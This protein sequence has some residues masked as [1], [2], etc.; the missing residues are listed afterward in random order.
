MTVSTKTGQEVL[1]ELSD[2]IED[3]FQ[4]TTT[5][6]GN[7]GGTTLTDTGLGRFGTDQL[8]DQWVRFTSG[9]NDN[10]IVRIKSNTGTSITFVRAVTGQVANSVTYEVHKYDPAMK[11][12]AIDRAMDLGFPALSRVRVDATLTGD[13]HQTEF[14]LPAEIRTG[15]FTAREELPMHG[16][17]SW[18]F[19]ATPQHDANDSNWAL[20]GA[21]ATRDLINA[22]NTTDRLVP[23]F[24]GPSTRILVADT[25]LTTY[26]QTVGAMTTVTAAAASGRQMTFGLWAYCRLGS[27]VTLTLTDDAGTTTSAA[28]DGRGWQ[29]LEVERDIDGDNSTTLSVAISVSSGDPLTLILSRSWFV[30]GTLPDQFLGHQFVVRPRRR[31]ASEQLLIF[32]R[33]VTLK[34]NVEIEGRGPLTALDGVDTATTEVDDQTL[35]LLAAT[36]AKELFRSVGIATDSLPT[37]ATKI[38]AADQ[39][40]TE[41]EREFE[42]KLARKPRLRG[43]YH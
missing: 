6:A 14:P 11:W 24:V 26:T 12:R 16:D 35:K 5:A 37:V 8:K 10:V 19:V 4:S 17:P 15:P 43:P 3:F 29:L 25:T 27:R 38:A 13:G 36:A 31:D 1:D 7:A 28:H 22:S 18:S 21:G 2:L 30:Y 39:L 23:K 42:V 33:P 34:F 32:E 9:T 41:L 40:K 20:A